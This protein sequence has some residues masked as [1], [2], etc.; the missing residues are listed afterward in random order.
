MCTVAGPRL[1]VT[2]I[3]VTQLDSR[4]P[5]NSQRSWILSDQSEDRDSVQWPIRGLETVEPASIVTQPI[6]LV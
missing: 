4:D 3:R 5:I 2:A 6:Y 1:V